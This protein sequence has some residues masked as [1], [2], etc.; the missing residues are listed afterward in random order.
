MSEKSEVEVH[1]I[2]D[3]IRAILEPLDENDRAGVLTAIIL[4]SALQQEDYMLAVGRLFA[5]IVEFDE[6]VTRE[7]M[8]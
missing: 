4:W 3:T 5:R 2:I 7:I 1:R 6:E 8:Q